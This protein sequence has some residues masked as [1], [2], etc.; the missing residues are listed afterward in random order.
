MK[1]VLSFFL[2]IEDDS[3]D[4]YIVSKILP[5]EVYYEEFVDAVKGTEI[6]QLE[7]AAIR[8]VP[9]WIENNE[10]ARRSIHEGSR[11]MYEECKE[12]FERNIRKN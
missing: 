5:D 8:K 11:D 6:P 9:Y 2:G 7:K 1:E 4:E 10:E 3:L 12:A